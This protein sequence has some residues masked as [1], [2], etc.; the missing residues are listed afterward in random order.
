MVNMVVLRE[1]IKMIKDN[2]SETDIINDISKKY[3]WLEAGEFKECYKTALEKI[4]TGE[5]E[6]ILNKVEAKSTINMLKGEEYKLR[7]IE[8]YNEGCGA[9]EIGQ[10]VGRSQSAISALLKRLAADGRINKREIKE[11]DKSANVKKTKRVEAVNHPLHYNLGKIEC[12]DYI[13]DVLQDDYGFYIGNIIKYVAR[14]KG[15]NGL[16]DLKK[17]QWYLDRLVKIYK[18]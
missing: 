10:E 1:I 11:N 13:D 6:E 16:E 18:G 9:T 12:I 8:L 4:R 14:Y 2:K 15:K 17:A 5:D 7:V 3:L